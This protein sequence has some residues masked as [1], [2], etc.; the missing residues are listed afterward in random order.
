VIVASGEQAQVVAGSHGARIGGLA[1]ANSKG[2][3]S[4]GSLGDIVASLATD[5]EAILTNDKVQCGCG[6]FEDIGEQA[7]VEGWLLVEDVELSTESLLGREVVGENLSLQALGD[8]VIELKLG[9]EA[10]R[11]GPCLCQCETYGKSVGLQHSVGMEP[12]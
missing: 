3:L 5:E 10:V 12:T 6:S 4:D 7:G 1:V 11:R 8:R 2:V 9:I